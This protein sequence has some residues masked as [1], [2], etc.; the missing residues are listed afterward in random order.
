MASDVNK[1]LTEIENS[2]FDKGELFLYGHCDKDGEINASLC[3]EEAD[4]EAI[5]STL[6]YITMTVA[7]VLYENNTE[8]T[9]SDITN[10]LYTDLFGSLNLFLADLDRDK[11]AD[12]VR[13]EA[14]EL[15]TDCF[16]EFDFY[17]EYE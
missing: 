1:K 13:A 9:K 3:C 4:L 12:E 10:I 15:L 16:E 2:K 11:D 6:Q 5:E 7:K 14:A 8:L 17:D